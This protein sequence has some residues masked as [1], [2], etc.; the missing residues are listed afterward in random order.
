MKPKFV[1]QMTIY[2]LAQ[3]AGSKRSFVP[4][5]PKTGEP[6]RDSNGRI[7]VNTVDANE[8]SKPWKEMV[9]R[10]ARRVW[11]ARRLLTGPVYAEMVFYRT[12][13]AYR[14]GTG[15]NAGIVK[16]NAPA[17]PAS[18]PDVLKLARGVE[19]ALT[20]VVWEDD[21]A[22]VSL[23]LDKRYGASDCVVVKIGLLPETVADLESWDRVAE[24]SNGG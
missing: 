8:N 3:P 23:K 4:L 18:K 24:T 13:P 15:R 16:P 11:G 22:N 10:E 2:G 17:F 12:S 9:A 14:L 6:Y 19:D 21:A 7:I 5:H 1:F 20:G